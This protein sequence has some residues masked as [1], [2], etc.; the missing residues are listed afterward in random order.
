MSSIWTLCFWN[1][2]KLCSVRSL[3]PMCG[4][5]VSALVQD[6]YIYIYTYVC[7]WYNIYMYIYIY[8]IRWYTVNIPTYIY[9]TEVKLSNIFL[10]LY[11]HTWAHVHTWLHTCKNTFAIPRPRDCV[12]KSVPA[13]L[14]VAA[15]RGT[16]VLCD[17]RDVLGCCQLAV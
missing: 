9:I 4:Q 3:Q 15:C 7:V 14:A 16:A 8:I 1:H 12:G 5:A 6:I 11:V 10:H 2:F 13:P 17:A